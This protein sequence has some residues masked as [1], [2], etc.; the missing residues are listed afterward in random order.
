MDRLWLEPARVMTQAGLRPDPWQV[1][2]LKS[3]ADQI[4]LLCSRQVGK[5]QTAAAVA[6]KTALLEAPALV[7]IFSPSERQS[8]EFVARVTELYD[9]LNQPRPVQGAAPKSWYEKLVADSGKDDA[10]LALPEKERESALQLH[11]SNGSRIIGLPA[12]EAKVRCYSSVALVVFDEASRVPDDLY[13][14]V[15]PMLAVSGGR[16]LALTT[17][18]GKRGWFWKEWEEGEDWKRIKVPATACPRITPAFLG[19]ERRS[20]GERWYTQEYLCEFRDAEDALFR[21]EDIDRAMA[22]GIPLLF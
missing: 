13:K 19:K 22:D 14:A 18:F 7:L 20:L 21:S 12:S 10:W 9:T 16:A 1:D 15:R 6:L 8:G 11:L 2:L 3:H 5:T 17:P 4:A